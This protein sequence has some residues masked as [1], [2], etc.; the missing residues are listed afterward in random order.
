MCVRKRTASTSAVRPPHERNQSVPC[1]L[2]GVRGACRAVLARLPQFLGNEAC[3]PL[4]FPNPTPKGSGL[5][6]DFWP[7]GDTHRREEN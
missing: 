7:V 2:A 6:D 4:I 1:T 3:N 5:R